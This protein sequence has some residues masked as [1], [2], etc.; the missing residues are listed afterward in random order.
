MALAFSFNGVVFDDYAPRY[1]IMDNRNWYFDRIKKA[2][3]PRWPLQKQML[4]QNYTPHPKEIGEEPIEGVSERLMGYIYG[5]AP[6]PSVVN[7]NPAV[8]LAAITLKVNQR[9]GTITVSGGPSDD[10]S[11]ITVEYDLDHT[12]GHSFVVNV[13]MGE[14][15]NAIADSIARGGFFMGRASVSGDV[16]TVT[17]NFGHTI[18]RLTATITAV[19]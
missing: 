6:P 12:T 4:K 2:M 15:P 3:V 16:V 18:A 10:H 11:M 1:L 7:P 13:A 17:P 8:I 9:A 14:L 19:H 5:E